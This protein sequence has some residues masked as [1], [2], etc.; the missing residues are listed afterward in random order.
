MTK[1]NL[2]IE[3]SVTETRRIPLK[4]NPTDKELE[5]I[6]GQSGKTAYDLTSD[7]LDF[8]AQEVREV[9]FNWVKIKI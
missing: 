1:K 2:Y 3:V 7:I 6:K 9:K 5:I 8:K 4:R